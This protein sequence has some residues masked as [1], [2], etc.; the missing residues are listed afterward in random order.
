M[1]GTEGYN[2]SR[3][4]EIAVIC[5]LSGDNQVEFDSIK[6]FLA[7]PQFQ[8]A[9]GAEQLVP[10][11]G[12]KPVEDLAVDQVLDVSRNPQLD[13]LHNAA[14]AGIAL[15]IVTEDKRGDNYNRLMTAYGFL[16]ARLGNRRVHLIHHNR[17]MVDNFRIATGEFVHGFDDSLN[18]IGERVPKIALATGE[19]LED[20]LQGLFEIERIALPSV[21]DQ[22]VFRR[23]DFGARRRLDILGLRF[24]RLE[25]QLDKI[26]TQMI[27][28]PDLFINVMMPGREVVQNNLYLAG[29]LQSNGTETERFLRGAQRLAKSGRFDEDVLSRV[30]FFS[31]QHIPTFMAVA[32]DLN[33][34]EGRILITPVFPRTRSVGDGRLRPRFLI[35]NKQSP[36]GVYHS[37]AS[38]LE[39][40]IAEARDENSWTLDQTAE[41]ERYIEDLADIPGYKK[42]DQS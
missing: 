17:I 24:G 23:E 40:F 41:H 14:K 28:K 37:Y 16:S 22:V 34:P 11:A 3:P 7:S 32:A 2:G 13:D 5:A 39:D 4:V 27:D 1:E 38:L 21:P 31:I 26:L 8:N 6:K 42:D 12:F 33:A 20:D 25:E 36:L 9:F 18:E 30:R 35:R 19:P 10:L 29:R 15:V